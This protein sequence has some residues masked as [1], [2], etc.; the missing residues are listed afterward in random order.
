MDEGVI[1]VLI[2]GLLF[3]GFVGSCTRAESI[4][5]DCLADQYTYI[6]LMRFKCELVKPRSA[7]PNAK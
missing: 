1:G 5:E 7:I 3:G 6:D 2:I 4:Q